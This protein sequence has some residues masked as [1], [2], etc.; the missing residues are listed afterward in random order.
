[1]KVVFGKAGPFNWKQA[2]QLA[3]EHPAHQ[4]YFARKLWGYFIPE[5]A[6]DETQAGLEELYVH[7][8][9][10][11]SARCWRRSSSTR[12]STKGRG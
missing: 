8:G 6:D 9:A 2:V 4:T 10:T 7:L 11:R 3:I 1:M 12:S 5:P